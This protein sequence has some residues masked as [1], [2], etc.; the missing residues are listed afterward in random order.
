MKRIIALL[1][2]LILGF[3]L[4]ACGQQEEKIQYPV[5]FY[6]LQIP[7]NPMN[8]G[9]DDSVITPV[10]R[11]AFGIRNDLTAL[12]NCYLEDPGTEET[13]S[14]FP[15]GTS[16][17]AVHFDQ[18]TVE[19]TLTDEFAQLSGFDLTL[20]CACMTQ[21]VLDLTGAETVR[22]RAETE[23][24]DGRPAITMRRENLVLTDNATQSI[25]NDR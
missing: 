12:L 19:L 1:L 9:S 3:G 23:Q 2:I 22:I 8:H 5:S 18:D 6:L 17:V 13:Y 20:A 25:D 21:T 16:V 24:L 11:E 15:I 14:P 10:V 7:Q 4:S